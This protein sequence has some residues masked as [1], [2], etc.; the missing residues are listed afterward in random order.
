MTLVV[1]MRHVRAANLCSKGARVW[2]AAH[3]LSWNEFLANGVQADRLRQCNDA[4]A[5]R[6]IAAAEREAEQ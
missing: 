2:F 6:A 3:G 5:D 1:Y 4:L